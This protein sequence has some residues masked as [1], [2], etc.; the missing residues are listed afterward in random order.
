MAGP[1]GRFKYTSDDGT[2]YV[3]RLDASNAALSGA[4]ASDGTEDNPPK[5]FR[6]RYRLV[7]NSAGKQRRIVSVTASH[8]LFTSAGTV[9]LPDYSTTPS[10]STTWTKMGAIGERRLNR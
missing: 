4:T 5:G 7:Q 6:P 9:S 10:T 1:M 8:A 3:V 2:V